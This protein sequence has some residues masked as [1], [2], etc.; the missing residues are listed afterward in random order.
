VETVYY[1]VLGSQLTTVP[2]YN[3]EKI[4][5]VGTGT[6]EWA[7]AMG[8]EYTDAEV[9]GTDIAK[10]QP[11]SAPRNVFFEID[12]AEEEGGWMRQENE[13][14]LVH[15]RSMAGAFT[16]WSYL[17]RETFKHLK[18]GGW[19]EVIDFDDHNAFLSYFDPDSPTTRYVRTLNEAAKKSGRLRGTN[20]LQPQKLRE[21]GFVNVSITDKAIPMGVWPED[22]TEREIGKYFLVTNLC[23]IEAAAIRVITEQ[24][25][26]DIKDL[27]KLCAE[28]TEEIRSVGMDA[29]RGHGISLKIR[30]MTGRKPGGGMLEVDEMDGSS[31]MG[32]SVKT[33]TQTN[34]EASGSS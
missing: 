30:I 18:P 17:Y 29:E 5:D 12:D 1:Q 6:G 8:E 25:G 24:L 33:I 2:L 23:G 22:K 28:A 16:D 26:W 7:M 10:I 4:L 31:T 15:F 21:V 9:I 32:D 11:S 14:D 20:H 19:I 3:P 13:F 34:G 27:Q